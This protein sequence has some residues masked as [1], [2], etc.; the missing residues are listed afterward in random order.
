MNTANFNFLDKLTCK[1][2][3]SATA[4]YIARNDTVLDFGCGV[5]HY[6]LNWG[7]NKF[8]VG[9]GLDYDIKDCQKENIRLLNYKFQGKLPFGDNFFDKVFLLAVLE[10]IKENDASMLF[11]EFSRVLK[12]DGQIIITTP[13][14]RGKAA[15]EFLAL[16]LR[17][18]S[19]EEISDHKHYY[20]ENEV[21]NLAIANGLK[22]VSF[23]TFQFGLNSLYV[24]G[25]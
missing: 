25:K 1:Y 21:S 8:R 5:Q 4:K 9:Y 2:R 22:V 14:I 17:I 7:K 20:T 19:F 18:L 15:L 24:I 6:L 23:K 10:H 12:K 11:S 13:T 16:K 3:L